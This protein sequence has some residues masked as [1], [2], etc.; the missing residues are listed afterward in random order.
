LHANAPEHVPARVE[1][2][3]GAAGMSRATAHAQ[4]AAGLQATVHLRRAPNGHRRIESVAVLA[5]YTS[6]VVQARVAAVLGPDD[7]RPGPAADSL[8]R[9]LGLL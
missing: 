4:L 8:H 6:G 7:V 1:A 9:M 2:L 5:A 3:A